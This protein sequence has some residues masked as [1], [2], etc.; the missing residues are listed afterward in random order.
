[1]ELKI[2]LLP[3]LSL[4]GA[5]QGL[6]L[7]SV[8]FFQ[9]RGNRQ[10]NRIFAALVFLFSLRL[11]EVA[12][13]WSTFFLAFPHL[14]FTTSPFP[15][16]FGVLLYF[17]AIA[18]SGRIPALRKRDAYH[19][20]PFLAYIARLFRFYIQSGDRK[21]VLLKRYIYSDS[22]ELSQMFFLTKAAQDVLMLFYIILTL[23]LL[24]EHGR[25]V[26]K[27]ARA[28]Q[29]KIKW[30]TR[31]TVGLGVFVLLDSAHVIELGFFGYE[32]IKEVY[33]PLILFSAGVIYMLGYVALK[34]PEVIS[35]GVHLTGPPRYEKSTLNSNRVDAYASR[36]VAAMEEEKLYTDSALKLSDLAEKLGIAPHHLSQVLNVK[37]RKNFF[38]FVNSYRI[39]EAKHRLSQPQHN[40]FTILSIAHEVGFNN[41]ASFNSAFKKHTGM[42]PSQ[43][44][45]SSSN[46]P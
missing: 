34:Q 12:G 35:G 31:L 26:A 5:V 13:Y 37:L 6:F 42:T 46:G 32:Y 39:D 1:M 33:S 29:A 21:L 20:I 14:A 25:R 10:A 9:R 38:D 18:L 40:H 27:A 24:R 3:A 19:F 30:L 22:P 2:D 43:F 15:F 4:L 11:M 23:R 7:A 17:Y 45:D 41:K 16:L 36:L 44:R 28:E 8:L